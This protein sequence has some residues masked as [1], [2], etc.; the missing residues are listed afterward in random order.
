MSR[1]SMRYQ[2]Q[3]PNRT[4]LSIEHRTLSIR[5]ESLLNCWGLKSTRLCTVYNSGESVFNGR[6]WSVENWR[7]NRGP[8]VMSTQNGNQ[9][10]VI[11]KI[12][13]TRISSVERMLRAV[14]F[15]SN[16]WWANVVILTETMGCGDDGADHTVIPI[17][18]TVCDFHKWLTGRSR[19]TRN[20]T[21]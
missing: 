8:S 12:E 19:P 21:P 15:S 14:V 20:Y 10:S 5:F 18:I 4:S 3:A 11:P 2:G 7:S 9:T 13:M 6:W 1:D 16:V 17:E